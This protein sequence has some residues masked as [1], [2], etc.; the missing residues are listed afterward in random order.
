[1][2]YPSSLAPLFLQFSLAFTDPTYQRWRVLMQAA[3]LTTGRRTISNMLRTQQHLAKGAP[4]SYHRVFSK[5]RWSLWPLARALAT[6]IIQMWIPRGLI[7]LAGDDTVLEHR[8][9]KVYGKCRHRDAQ[10][11]SHSYVAHLFGH[12]WV[13]L[14]ILVHFPFTSRPWALPV[15]MALYRSAKWNQEHGRRHK[16]APQLMRQLLCVLLRW[17]PERKFTFTGDGGF[18]PHESAAQAQRYRSRLTFVGRFHPKANLYGP[19]PSHSTSKVGRPRKRG[20]A[21]PSPEKVAAKSR[22]RRRNVSWYGGERRQVAIVT[23]T[24]WWYRGGT[25]LVE[26]R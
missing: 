23:G 1:M 14:S 20:R 17:F 13:V 3:I 6:Y 15:L 24:G 12:K 16:T 5:R 22:R 9:K 19:P 7:Y 21:L 8:G 26:V 10:R 2:L 11:S 18:S 4:S 25:A